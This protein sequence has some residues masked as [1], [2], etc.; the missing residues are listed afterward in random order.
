MSHPFISLAHFAS[1]S[2]VLP[3]STT[4]SK[5]SNSSSTPPLFH[6]CSCYCSSFS[7]LGEILR[8]NIEI[9]S[10]QN[11]LNPLSSRL[12]LHSFSKQWLQ[13]N[14]GILYAFSKQLN[15]AGGKKITELV[16]WNCF[17]YNTQTSKQNSTL[18]LS[19]YIFILSILSHSPWW[20]FLVFSSTVL[21]HII[22]STSP[23]NY[24]Q[25]TILPHTWE[26]EMDKNKIF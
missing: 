20:L 8:F 3:C 16:D 15:I 19:Y 4:L 1:F 24:S 25:F 9:L 12:S 26:K 18:T 21:K 5:S 17:K 10:L 2:Q 6:C 23:S 14:P 7:F 22:P 11:T 13:L